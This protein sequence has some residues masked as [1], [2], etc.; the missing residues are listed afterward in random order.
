M[1]KQE[2]T[3]VSGDSGSPEPAPLRIGARVV[4]DLLRI[5]SNAPATDRIRLTPNRSRHGVAMLRGTLLSLQREQLHQ[6]IQS[7]VVDALCLHC[8]GLDVAMPVAEPDWGAIILIDRLFDELLATKGLDSQAMDWLQNLRWPVLRYA[9]QDYSFFFTPQNLVRRFLNQS[10]LALLSSTEKSRL[11]YRQQLM[12]FQQRMLEGFQKEAGELNAICIEAQSWFAGQ[13]EKVEKIEEQLRSLESARQKENVA[14]PRVV[15]EL[16]R[17]A[18]GKLLPE[19]VVEFLYGIWRKSLFQVSMREGENG[20]TWKRQVRT[21]ESI[22]EFCFG[23]LSDDP[24]QRGKHAGFYP[25]LMKNVKVLLENVAADN[26]GMEQ[27]IE[28]LELVLSAILNRAVPPMQEA[29][30]LQASQSHVASI[31]MKRASAHAQRRIEQLQE[32]DCIRMK[33]ATGEHELCRISLKAEGDAPW[34]LVSQSGKT[35][36]KKNALQLAQAFE[37][38]VMDVLTDTLFWDKALDTQLQK[39]HVEWQ[40]QQREQQ[41]EALR[42]QQEKAQRDELE[43]AAEREQAALS[44]LALAAIEEEVP[45]K[46]ETESRTEE[47]LKDSLLS[48]EDMESEDEQEEVGDYL[49]PRPISEQELETA[50]QAIDQIQVGGWI[51]QQT[52]DGEQRCKLAVKIRGRDKLVFVNR[53]GIKILEINKQ[54]LARLLVYGAVSILD[55]GAAF[56]STLERVV[57]SIQKEKR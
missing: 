6:A 1:Q 42:Q 25:V 29:P 30:R 7:T 52:S 20:V 23:C 53:V 44:E 27:V 10:F 19:M 41:Q 8:S 46:P 22:V 15:A 14:E 21:T 12:D 34:V 43:K 24:E 40:Q 37:G 5:Q 39:L 28:P 35:V 33:T 54:E 9:L 50:V 13:N 4:V 16:N 49:A 45:E 38:G 17:I 36:A 31:E 51:A 32:G 47:V 18:G 56:D 48:L 57:R 55:T 2:H 26:G 3:P 11:V